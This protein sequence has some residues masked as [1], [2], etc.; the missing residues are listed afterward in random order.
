MNWMAPEVLERPYP[1]MVYK[2]RKYKLIVIMIMILILINNILITL[3]TYSK[4]IVSYKL[5]VVIVN[6]D[7]NS[8]LLH[9]I[10]VLRTLNF[11]HDCSCNIP[12][13]RLTTEV[14]SKLSLCWNDFLRLPFN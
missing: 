5:K 1:F 2:K 6:Y 9:Y 10:S 4:Q 7:N 8:T 14:K 12:L 3:L 13:V 11:V